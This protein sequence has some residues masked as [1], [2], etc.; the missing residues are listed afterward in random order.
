M[1]EMV[2]YQNFESPKQIVAQSNTNYII[3]KNGKIFIFP[4]TTTEG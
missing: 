3:D 4:I 2:V 1:N